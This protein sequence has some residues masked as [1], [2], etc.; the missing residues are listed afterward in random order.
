MEIL[1]KNA[2]VFTENNFGKFDVLVTDN[3]ITKVEPNIE[4]GNFDVVY[5]LENLYLLPGLID[6]HT[7]LRE[8][9]FIYK[10]TIKTGTAAAARGG[11]TSICAMPNLNPVPDSLENLSPQL[12]AIKK[13]AL[14]NVYPYGSITKKEEGQEL[15]NFEEIKD[16]V[17]AFSDDGKG[18]Q[19]ENMMEEAMKQA[20]KLNKKIVAHCEENSLLKGGYIHNGEYAKLNNHKGICSESEWKPIKRDIELSKKTGCEYHVCH[21][22]AK[23]SVQIIREAKKQGI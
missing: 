11:Y 23:E 15:S 1:F 21:I 4:L 2:T 8:P 20:K 10:E 12:D 18:V 9:G 14:I 5:N 22:S 6:V 3:K 17:I 13:D 19:D 16:F 7:H